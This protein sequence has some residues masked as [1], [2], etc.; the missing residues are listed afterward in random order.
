M[1]NPPT[2]QQQ[3]MVGRQVHGYE[4]L[5]LLGS[6]GMGQVYLAR[7]LKLD[8]LRAIKVILADMA[9]KSTAAKRFRREG[10]ALNRLQHSNIVNLVDFG[11]LDDGALYLV[12]Q[13]IE[14]RN[15]QQVVDSGGPLPVGD[16]VRVVKQLADALEYAH[17]LDIVH[18]DLKPQNIILHDDDPRYV[19]VIDFGLVKLVGGDTMTKLTA[20]EHLVGTPLYMSP[21]QGL[22]GEIG[23]PADVYAL[24]ALA[25]FILSGRPPFTGAT[26]PAL[27]C[28][29]CYETPESLA[30]RCPDLP[31]GLA[32]FLLKCLAKE[33]GARPSA[34][35]VVTELGAMFQYLPAPAPRPIPVQPSVATTIWPDTELAPDSSD[36]GQIV[37]ALANQITAVLHAVAAAMSD[38]GVLAL[39]A[40]SRLEQLDNLKEVITNLEMDGALM[41]SQL[42]EIGPDSGRDLDHQRDQL[43]SRAADL[44]GQLRREYRNLFGDVALSRPHV[45]NPSLLAYLAQ[46]DALVEKYQKLCNHQVLM[47]GTQ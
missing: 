8:A 1:A 21:E 26:L 41:D 4:L 37:A 24:A 20:D 16:G 2:S 44:N 34:A 31:P 46:L 6:G 30:V 29:H 13:Y 40:K 43:R 12:M 47:K 39:S 28:A 35:E 33:P 15:L 38:Q 17:R 9:A 19:K 5:S 25:Y 10:M 23:G 3:S 45:D 7:H 18:R 11:H 36:D 22:A 14:G 32:E 42:E 27:I